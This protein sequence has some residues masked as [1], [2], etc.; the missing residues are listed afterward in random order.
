VIRTTAVAGECDGAMVVRLA[1]PPV[2][3]AANDALIS[4]L[5]ELLHLPRHAVRIVSGERSRR[6]RL[7]IDGVTADSMR[8]LTRG[9]DVR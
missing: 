2:E 6:K 1:V 4:Y 5:A 9:S 7:A 8:E 3:G